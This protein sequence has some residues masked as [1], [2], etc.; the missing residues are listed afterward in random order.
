MLSD[1]FED[2][3]RWFSPSILRLP[4]STVSRPGPVF[5]PTESVPT[6]DVSNSI[7]A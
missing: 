6:Q 5:G 4:S 3:G 7:Q 1:R 2:L